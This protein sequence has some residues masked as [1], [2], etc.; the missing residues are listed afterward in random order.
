MFY[1]KLLV[2]VSTVIF[3]KQFL[4]KDEEVGIFQNFQHTADDPGDLRLWKVP[5]VILAIMYTYI[6]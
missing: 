6:K 2:I 4:T 1:E 3:N 5:V